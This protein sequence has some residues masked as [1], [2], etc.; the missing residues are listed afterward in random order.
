[1][2]YRSLTLEAKAILREGIFYIRRV[3]RDQAEKDLNKSHRKLIMEPYSG[4][5]KE[6][7]KEKL[8]MDEQFDKDSIEINTDF[9]EDDENIRNALKLE[10][11]DLL[12][13]EQTS[14]GQS[15]IADLPKK[16]KLG[17]LKKILLLAGAFFLV[18]LLI[19]VWLAGTKSGRRIL[20]RLAGGMIYSKVGQEEEVATNSV[21]KPYKGRENKA[22]EPREEAVKEEKEAPVPKKE[23]PPRQEDYVSNYL[24]FGVEEIFHAKNTDTMMIVSVNTRDKSIKLTSLLRDTYVKP[25]DDD[26]QKLNSFYSIG[27]A[28]MLT[29]VIEKKYRIKLDGYG[30]I[31]FEAFEYI[32]DYLD[33]ID[34][35]LGEEE[36]EYLNTT[37][38]ISNPKN[39]NVVPGWNHLNGNQVLGYC[40]VRKCVTLGGAND[41]YG[42]TLRQR[43]VLE[44][45]FDRYKS[46]NLF[47]LLFMADD[48]L[49][50]IKTN[51]TR[52]Q[53][54]KLLEDVLE[55]RITAMDTL[56]LPANGTFETPK[57]YN[58]IDDP[59]V[60]DWDANILRLYRFIFL[61]SEEEAKRK[62]LEYKE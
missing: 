9:A 51:L 36:A 31:N 26:P 57:E 12:R 43:R 27:G 56:R 16:R 21:I 58:G 4:T 22:S 24:I 52:S 38:Y 17:S 53:I 25:E 62:L 29:E 30:Y 28:G 7:D 20:Y 34:I 46:G 41:D 3:G 8:F 19:V 10:V 48:I 60:I 23:I 2:E 55:N 18:L 13:Q 6:K 40:R 32:I 39:R 50:Y 5:S 61:D 59:L 35:E 54:E 44:A 37:N 15:T 1:M 14:S 42:R 47:D 33:G 11:E 45:I 49:G